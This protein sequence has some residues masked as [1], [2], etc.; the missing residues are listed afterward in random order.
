MNSYR[1]LPP[2]A[3][4]RLLQQAVGC[5]VQECQPAAV[6]PIA[7]WWGIGRILRP[8][9][10]LLGTP[11]M[12][13]AP[14]LHANHWWQRVFFADPQAPLAAESGFWPWSPQEQTR[15]MCVWVPSQQG[16][17]SG[18]RPR[19]YR[20]NDAKL[21]SSSLAEAASSVVASSK[22]TSI[23]SWAHRLHD[24]LSCWNSLFSQ[25][26]Q[27]FFIANGKWARKK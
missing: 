22:P 15:G 1:I 24:C 2:E 11:K 17:Q 9:A 21:D 7:F 4:S 13:Q 25:T 23:P 16:S 27:F 3:L 18:W 10:S 20:I 19:P 14:L 26:F 6:S 12:K 8:Q 5:Q